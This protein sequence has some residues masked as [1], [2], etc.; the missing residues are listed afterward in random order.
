MHT[1]T[2]TYLHTYR[3]TTETKDDEFTNQEVQNAVQGMGNK[4]APRG[5]GIPNEVWKAVVAILPKYLTAIYKGCL[6]EGVFPNRWKKSKIIPAVK[7]GKK[8]AM[9]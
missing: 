8:E 5:D 7:Q 4:K 2:H 9:R 3:H 6:K 1:Y